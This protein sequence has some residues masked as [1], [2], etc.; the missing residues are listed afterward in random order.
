[1]RMKWTSRAHPISDIRDWKRNNRLELKPDFQRNVVW[2]KSAQIALIDTILHNIP[3]PK[4]YI[5]AFVKNENTYR[6]VID[7]QQRLTAIIEF[8][9]NRLRLKRA[10]LSEEFSDYDGKTFQELPE[11]VRNDILQYNVD[12]NEISNTTEDEVRDMYA[13]VNKYTVQLNKQELRRADYPGDLMSVAEELSNFPYF[14]S[15]KMFTTGQRR[16]MLDVEYILELLCIIL[17]GE[18]DKKDNLDEICERYVTLP[19][20]FVSDNEE[21]FAGLLERFFISNP[22]TLEDAEELKGFKIRFSK[23][24]EGSKSLVFT[25]CKVLSDLMDIFDDSFPI[26]KT[27]FRQ[28]AD[29][30]SLFSAVFALQKDGRRL[31]DT[32][33]IELRMQLKI[34]TEGIEPHSKN[35]HFSNY[36]IKCISDANSLGSRQWRREFLNR[37]LES[38][39]SSRETGGGN[40]FSK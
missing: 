31:D 19:G 5:Q 11:E 22:E 8:I 27:R 21:S 18:Q 1:M 32:K 35:E 13:R 15:A 28:K 24:P 36:A 7:G 3:F 9:E 38:A 34:L 40:E 20:T 33:L 39:Y 23:M 12:F 6:I 37:Y 10:N 30:Y 17:V 26:A 25:F 16:R 4:I 2:T 14:D 29:F